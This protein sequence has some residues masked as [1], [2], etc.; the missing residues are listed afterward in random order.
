MKR[1]EVAEWFNNEFINKG[2]TFKLEYHATKYAVLLKTDSSNGFFVG[3]PERKVI[4]GQY[5]YPTI[6]TV[7]QH[8]GE[9]NTTYILVSVIKKNNLTEFGELINFK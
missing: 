8:K 3:V 5:F 1:E 4:D 9:V 2:A 7:Y 6:Q